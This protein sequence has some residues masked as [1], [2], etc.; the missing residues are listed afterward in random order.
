MR[1]EEMQMLRT[2]Y[3]SG[4]MSAGQIAGYVQS[5]RNEYLESQKAQWEYK[6]GQWYRIGADGPQ[7]FGEPN[8]A[9]ESQSN[10]FGLTPMFVQDAEG[11]VI[12]T[13][14]SKRGGAQP[15]QMPEGYSVPSGVEKIDLGTQF[16]LQDKRTGNI[17]GYLP[18]DVEGEAAA[19][20]IGT[21]RGEAQMA[22][23]GALQKAEQAI[24]IIDQL[25]EH[26]GRETATGLSGMVDPRNYLPGTE[27]TDFH[28][29]K[30]Q[31]QG[32]AFLEAFESLKG[33]GVI[34]E[35]E[36]M[37]ATEALARLDTAQSD[38]AYE[39]ALRD[40]RSVIEIG[41]ERARQ[42][43]GQEPQ[44][45]APDVAPTGQPNTTSTGVPWRIVE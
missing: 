23:P 3:D 20:E 4:E 44:Q 32:K 7:P 10:E 13:Q 36:G 22:L 17:V 29:M 42:R 37:K 39:A 21:Q 24:N 18:K 38:E 45:Q 35:V 8:Q 31:L 41:T 19:K 11:N 27:A 25:I 12:P 33:G 14:L 26:P 1:P 6:D 5:K 34:T 9:A 2:L 28:V 16:A 40:F 30:R 15:V 43:A